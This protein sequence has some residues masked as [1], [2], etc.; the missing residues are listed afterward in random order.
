MANTGGFLDESIWRDRDFRALPRTAQATFA[1]L[2]S[3][4]ELDRAGLLPLQITKWAKACHAMTIDDLCAD[5]KA[6]QAARFV[7]I[8]E[9]TDEL[10]VRSYMRRSNVIKQPNLLK[11]ALKCAAMAASDSLRH[12]L[13]VELRRMGRK[14]TISTADDIDPGE[15]PE[16]LPEPFANPSETLPEPLNPSGTPREPRGVGEGEGVVTS[17]G[18][19]VGGSHAHVRTREAP[20]PATPSNDPP[21]TTCPQHPNGTDQPCRPCA[22]TRHRRDAWTTEHHRLEAENRHT[23][24]IATA[25]LRTAEIDACDLCDHTGYRD[26]RVCHHDPHQDERNTRGMEKVRKALTHKATQ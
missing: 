4:K 20:E 22:E 7:C 25:E 13:A 19:Y 8:D 17:V 11:N 3:Q 15:P 26:S 1:Q 23:E 18:G 2:L 9:D 21:P 16:T 24:R 10:L 14:D 5:L 6:L 12:E